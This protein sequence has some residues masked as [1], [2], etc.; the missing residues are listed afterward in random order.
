MSEYQTVKEIAPEVL[1]ARKHSRAKTRLMQGGA[2]AA[3]TAALF[4]PSPNKQ[5]LAG[6]VGT[7]TTAA[8]LRISPKPKA[9]AKFT[10]PRGEAGIDINAKQTLVAPEQLA[11]ANIEV[12]AEDKES[13][14]ASTVKILI[15]LKDSFDDWQ[16]WC[17]GDVISRHIEVTDDSGSTS[18]VEKRGV[19]L[20]AHCLDADNVGTDRGLMMTKSTGKAINVIDQTKYD[21]AI[22]DPK[23]PFYPQTFT[24]IGRVTGISVSTET[25]AAFFQVEDVEDTVGQGSWPRAFSD[26][27]A[28][29]YDNLQNQ[30]QIGER[31]AIYGIP[32]SSGNRPV[33]GY[34]WYLGKFIAP[35]EIRPM[36]VD[37][38]AIRAKQPAYDGCEFGASG[39]IALGKHFRSGP[40]A[41]RMDRV[42]DAETVLDRRGLRRADGVAYMLALESYISSMPENRAYFSRLTGI[43]VTPDMT[44]CMFTSL[45][46]SGMQALVEGM[47][48]KLPNTPPTEYSNQK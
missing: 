20:A 42:F 7:E 43:K 46:D 13:L 21:Y 12:S 44:I 27:P 35:N 47:T 32:E 28:I 6:K 4:A 22:A 3:A 29:S 8:E 18:T 36:P 30:P 1:P 37:M 31:V 38:V 40:L 15:R 26:I 16:P 9:A 48:R 5:H 39:S 17:T 45:D 24:P 10:I 11:G 2:I 25:D 23:D 41:R 19:M 33:V 34:G 14:S